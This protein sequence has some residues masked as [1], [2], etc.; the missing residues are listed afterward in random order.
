M[1]SR[2]PG[3]TFAVSIAA[4]PGAQGTVENANPRT[5]WPLVACAGALVG[6]ILAEVV[7]LDCYGVRASRQ[8]AGASWSNQLV[9]DHP[10]RR[11]RAW[12]TS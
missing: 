10:G 2:C 5:A 3:N 7:V 1:N 4:T 8:N 9:H 12:Q 11:K 6:W